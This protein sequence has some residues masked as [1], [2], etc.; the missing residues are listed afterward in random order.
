[1]GEVNI[2]GGDYAMRIWLNPSKMAQYGLVPSDITNV[3]GEENVES[4]VGTVGAQSDNT[5][6]YT[7]KYRGRYETSRRVRQS[8]R[9]VIPNGE[10]LSLKDVARIELV[11]SH[12][13]TTA[14]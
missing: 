4:P 6:Q 8:R 2:V 14:R 3:L 10:V 7:L 5:F 13:T 12:T 9:Q 11:L 1:V